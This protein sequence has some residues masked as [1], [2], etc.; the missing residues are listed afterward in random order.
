MSD[1]KSREDKI[2]VFTLLVL[3]IVFNQNLALMPLLADEPTRALVS[4]E[5]LLRNNYIFPTLGNEAYLNKPP[6]FNWILAGAMY[7][8]KDYKE[9]HLRLISIIPLFAIAI[10]HYIVI[11]KEVNKKVALWSSLAF[12]TCGRILFYDS[13]MAYIDP[14]FSLLIVLNTYWI[15]I[16]SRKPLSLSFFVISYLFCLLSFF[17]KGLP[18]LSFQACTLLAVCIYREKFKSLLSLNHLTGIATFLLFAA[19]YYYEYSAY[20]NTSMLFANIVSQSSQRTPIATE[21]TDSFIHLVQFPVQFILDFSPFSFL[22]IFAFK[23]NTF[24][25]LKEN[26][27]IFLSFLFIVSNIWLYWISAETRARYLFMFLPMFFILVFYIYEKY[28]SSV[29]KKIIPVLVLLIGLG[30]ILTVIIL[31]F[32]KRFSFIE[33]KELIAAGIILGTGIFIFCNYRYKLPHILSVVIILILIR[34]TFNFYILPLREKESPESTN[35]IVGKQLGLITKNKSLTILNRAPINHDILY[36][37]TKERQALV[38]QDYTKAV[39]E[40]YLKNGKRL[41]SISIDSMSAYGIEKNI[42]DTISI[43]DSTFNQIRRKILADRIQQRNSLPKGYYICTQIDLIRYKLKPVK[44][45]NVTH[46]GLTLALAK[47]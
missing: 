23:K 44:F 46:E 11:S 16:Q 36:Y 47:K 31:S 15:F 21:I 25:I 28:A 5:M 24:S 39:S 26:E 8:I 2:F 34:I 38:E 1:L 29:S 6:L 33:Y 4:L 14:L 18:A 10:T 32:L 30:I 35:R 13:M 37:M 27:F 7:F 12:L 3:F 22:I 17:L 45:F 9:W 19:I 41:L 40:K 43:T 20:A 42:K